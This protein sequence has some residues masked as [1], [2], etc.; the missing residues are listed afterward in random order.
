[1]SLTTAI[2]QKS[3]H[4]FY[5]QAKSMQNKTKT[6]K[7]RQAFM[8]TCSIHNSTVLN[9]SCNIYINVLQTYIYMYSN[10]YEIGGC[11]L[12]LIPKP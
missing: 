1:M 3:N 4:N 8:Q 2:D 7:N 11:L 9:I 6:T 5:W 12:D 10:I